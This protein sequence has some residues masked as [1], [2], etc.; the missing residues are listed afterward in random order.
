[1]IRKFS[2]RRRS[3]DEAPAYLADLLDGL[4]AWR[5][6]YIEFATEPTPDQIA[7]ISG[8]V[9]DPLLDDVAVDVPIDG[10]TMV[11]V[12][13]KRGIV[14][15]ENDSIV[16]MCHLFGAEAVAAKVATTY[17]SR[18]PRLV[19]VITE[20]ACNPN[21]EELH[22]AEPD[23]DTLAPHGQ[24]LPA[25]TFDLRGLSDDELAAVG[26]GNGRQLNLDQMRHVRN[27][28][29]KAGLEAV[30]DVLLESLDARWSDHC[31]HTTWTSLGRLLHRLID[32]VKAIA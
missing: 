28:Q 5:E 2:G 16:A 23:Y 21:I 25:A 10:A 6:Y 17:A 12:A 4:L 22:R 9:A 29:D 7:A 11:Q 32:R 1:M 18:D 27:I 20:H 3:G 19:D 15:N 30:T 14:D 31:A 26:T 24:Y 8:A 13:Y